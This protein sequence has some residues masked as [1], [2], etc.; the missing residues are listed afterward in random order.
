MVGFNRRFAPLFTDLR[1]R[2]GRIDGPLSARYLVNA[3]RL[4][5]SSWYLNEELEGSRF[6]GEGGHFIDTLSALVG[7]DP[8]EVV[9]QR[10]D[11]GRSASR[12]GSPTARSRRSPMPRADSAA[13]RRRLSTSRRRPQRPAGQLHAGH[14]VDAAGEG[15]TSGR[16]PGR[17]RASARSWR[18]RRRRPA[19]WPM[20][21]PL[22][23]LVATTRATLAGR[24]QPRV[25]ERRRCE[26]GSAGT[27]AGCGRCRPGRFRA[28]DQ[29]RGGSRRGRRRHV[30]PG[31]SAPPAAGLARRAAQSRRVPPGRPN[32]VPTRV[33]APVRRRRPVLAGEWT[34]LG[35]AR[36]DI[37]DPDWFHDP[38]TG[39]TAPS[40]GFAFRI[41]HGTSRTRGTSSRSGSCPGTTT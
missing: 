30:R 6:A 13:S 3:G 41:H 2:F 15:A 16:S 38:V 22:D 32:P 33:R 31:S 23:S 26:P 35:V 5:P 27:C 10:T 19:G 36:P 4:D 37:A 20:P 17:T 12:C 18:V 40:D 34:V 21:I 9:A 7:H 24:G 39:R 28:D 1:D 8:V 11:R 29:D 14:R 25:R